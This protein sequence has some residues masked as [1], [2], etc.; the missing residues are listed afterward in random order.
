[1]RKNLPV[2]NREVHLSDTSNILSTTS[3]NSHITYVNDDFIKISGFTEAELIGQPHNLVRHPDM[4]TAAFEHMWATLK[5]GHSWMG[6]VKNRCKNGDHYWV[7]AFVTPISKN[8]SITE[9]QSVRT[10]ADPQSIRR[11]EQ[12]YAS[13][14]AGKA[15]PAKSKVSIPLKLMLW[16]VL[17]MLL[18]GFGSLLVSEFWLQLSLSLLAPVVLSTAAIFYLLAPLKQLR[19]LSASIVENPLSQKLYTNRNDE[20][21]GIEFAL[22]MLQ[23]ETGS[24][25]GRIHDASGKLT[26]HTRSSL[27]KVEAGNKVN[28]AQQTETDQIATAVTEM[29]ASIQQVASS[30]QVAANAAE[31]ADS[32]TASGRHLVE[33]TKGSIKSLEHELSKAA[34]AIHELEKQSFEI[35]KVLE[36]IRGVA[37]Q[38]NLLALNAAIEAARAG[39]QG[40]GFAVVADE[41]RS[42]AGRTRQS[43]TDIQSM[44]DTLQNRAQTA[45][46][47]MEQSSAQANECV[48]DAVEAALALESIGQKVNKISDMNVQIAMAAEQQGTVS[49]SI[50]RAVNSM[51]EAANDNV[52]IGKGNLES[53]TAVATLS[54]GLNE[55][56]QQFWMKRKS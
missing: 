52:H 43:T 2:T 38:T 24:V 56:A 21:G 37:E 8:G 22:R 51:Q 5:A 11:A 39:E 12:C 26:Q 40:R 13:L 49:E 6:L 47:A 9:I 53:A 44:I 1:M 42:L 29:A 7:S 14:H 15:V 33:K 10:K 32:E 4:P 36:V 18:G 3:P 41:V 30:A 45:V 16:V 20:F 27:Q 17:S 50:N 46:A 54:S 19:A 25:V 31:E 34:Q 48:S 28:A 23:A 35:S 55:L